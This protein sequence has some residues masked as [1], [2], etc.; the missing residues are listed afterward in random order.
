MKKPILLV[1]ILT[2]CT[3]YESSQGE[4]FLSKVD[5]VD[6]QD[7]RE[8]LGFFE[9][10][11][12]PLEPAFTPLPVGDNRPE[13][14]I[15]E[16]MKQ[17][18]ESGIVGALDELYPGIKSDDLF[19]T[20]RRGGLDDVPEMGDLV[21]TGAPWEQSIMW[22]NAETIG[23]WWDGFV[24][25]A[26]LTGNELAIEQSDRIVANLLASQDDDGYLGIYKPNLR[27]QHT[28]SNGELWAQTT[29]FRTLL[30]YYELTKD[31]A[32]LEAVEKG[33]AVT[34]NRYNAG[35]KNPFKLEN[36]F[37]GVTHGLMLTDVCE[38]L[39]RITG[40]ATYQEYAVY[41]YQAFSTYS[42]NRAFNDFRY[43]FLMQKD[44]LFTGHAVHTYEHIR[45]LVNAYYQTGYPE[46]KTAYENALD[47][48]SHCILPSGAGH[49]NEWI[50][51]MEAD[52]TSTAA[53]Y[54][55]M[56]ELRN[57]L[58]SLAQKTGDVQFADHAEKLTFN[59]MMGAR[60]EAGTAL[61]YGKH[62]NSFALDG[63]HHGLEQSHT[64]P[65]YKY[66]PTHSDPAVCCIPNYTRNLTYFLDQMWMKDGEGLV[67]MLYGP[68]SLTTE[69]NGTT[70]SIV[71]ETNYPFSDEI[72]LK[73]LSDVTTEFPISLRKPQWVNNMKV[74][75]KGAKIAEENG[76]I[77]V[78]GNWS[79]NEIIIRFTNEVQQLAHSGEQYFQ[80]GPLV[81]AYPI[82]HK[83]ETIKSYRLEGFTD[84]Y[85]HPTDSTFAHLVIAEA[86][87]EFATEAN[88]VFPW[89]NERTYLQ[90]NLVD[91]RS[92]TP[93]PTRL[94]PMGNTVLRRVTFP[95]N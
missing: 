1:C 80:R 68:S 39:F 25:H 18:L 32:V 59:G 42:I 45:T 17:D 61:A 10:D 33:M 15:L 49:G 86:N 82:P 29:A 78:R 6:V 64:D 36:A 51:G 66:S 55:S 37:G 5:Q 62:D 44:S 23:N 89:Y 57:S 77:K 14:W 56:L 30:G 46:L 7:D 87:F 76:F 8:A 13:G 74:E 92:G 70:V 83:N 67:A 71:Q 12:N 9:K 41:L 69:L 20:H 72:R 95:V 38:T 21:L 43:P 34:M 90:G 48:L 31:T 75:V 47:K 54:C 27:Y 4:D 22:W 84:Y 40:D 50:A 73:V 91:S 2:A 35:I 63:K 79:S 52:A 19:N 88:Q 26:Y 58:A 28:G 60:N 93:V 24:R 94:F 3:T 85:S 81:Y 16:L 11:R 53:E 65:R